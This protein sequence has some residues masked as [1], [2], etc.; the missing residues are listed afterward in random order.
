MF[1]LDTNFSWINNT[2]SSP[3]DNFE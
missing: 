1:V 2:T 3:N